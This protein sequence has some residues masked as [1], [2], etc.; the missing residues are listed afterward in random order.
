[1][2]RLRIE[3]FAAFVLAFAL[4]FALGELYLHHTLR[5]P[6]IFMGIVAII[7][8]TGA[9]FADYLAD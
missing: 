2:N 9:I 8:L 1:M 6:A 7:V 5:V 3:T 4:T